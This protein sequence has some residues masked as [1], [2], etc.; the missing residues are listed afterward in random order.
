MQK[1][2]IVFIAVLSILLLNACKKE[3]TKNVSKVYKVPSIAL[4]GSEAISLPVGGAYVDAGATYTAEDG[5]VSTIQPKTN[6]VNTAVPGIYY[7]TFEETS[8]SGVF[9]TE[10]TRT[11]AVTFQGGTTDYSGTY[12]RSATGVNAFVTKVAN[13]L[14]KVQNP[15][16]AAGHE[17]V[18]V[19]FIETALNTFAGP[20]QEEAG[21]HL[22]PIRIVEIVF[23]ATGGSWKILDSPYYGTGTRSF[24]KQ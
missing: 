19:Y 4:K 21:L 15:G 17:G 13:G 20:T 8:A 2:K 14:Y 5:T 10:T 12:K 6:T 9:H 23:T 1:I 7:V 3:T 24:V 16:G 11:V 22:G 18:I